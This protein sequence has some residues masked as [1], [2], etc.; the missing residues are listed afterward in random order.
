L[1]VIIAVA[2]LAARFA[3]SGYPLVSHLFGN[4]SIELGVVENFAFAAL[5]YVSHI[6]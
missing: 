3:I 1:Y 6:S 2:E 5:R 4:T